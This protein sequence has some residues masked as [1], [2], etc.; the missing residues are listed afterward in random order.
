MS[1]KSELSYKLQTFMRLSIQLIRAIGDM[2]RGLT[3]PEEPEVIMEKIIS[4]DRQMRENVSRLKEHQQ[5]QKG[6]LRLQ[7]KIQDRHA[8]IMDLAI[9]ILTAELL[10]RQ[11]VDELRPSVELVKNT[12]RI[13]DRV[14]LDDV[15]QC[16]YNIAYNTGLLDVP[17][18]PEAPPRIAFQVPFPEERTMRATRIYDAYFSEREGVRADTQT[19][20]RESVMNLLD[21]GF[22]ANSDAESLKAERE[23][24]KEETTQFVLGFSDE[25]ND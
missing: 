8:D 23:N 4:V 20:A 5:F 13:R 7:S 2:N 15:V 25:E 10:L 14:R 24:S 11:A 9:R 16:S 1:V 18:I 21:I 22:E 17:H 12:S 6:I 19:E 3:V